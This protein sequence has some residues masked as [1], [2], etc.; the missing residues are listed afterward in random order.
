MPKSYKKLQKLLTFDNLMIRLDQQFKEMFDHR[1]NNATYSLA[2]VLKSG[3][4]MFSLKSP[5]LLSFQEQTRIE[6]RNLKQIY[7]IGKIPAD[8]QMRVILDGVE[9]D[10]IRDMFPV[11]YGRLKQAGVIKEYEY[12]KKHLLVSIDGVEHF[13]STRI[14]CANCTR[15]T[16]RDGV[17]SYQ[18]AALAAVIV[19]PEQKEVLAL[20]FEPIV[21]QDGED[22]N[23]CERVAVKRLSESLNERYPDTLMI[24]VEDALYANAPHIRQ[25]GEQGWNFIISVKPESHKSL[26]KQFAWRRESGQVKS[27]ETT[28]E[29]RLRRC[30]SWTEDLYLCDRAADLKVNCLWY[31]EQDAA[32]KITRWTWITRLPLERRTVEKV[33]NAGRA[34]W[35]IENETFNT[36]KNQ[37]YNFEHNDGHGEKNLASVLAMLMML[38]FLVDQIQERCCELFARLRAGLRTRAKLWETMRSLF[39]VVA[40]RSMTSLYI[41]MAGLYEIKLN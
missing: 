28:D 4:A 22:K 5:S 32:G 37:G 39:K 9:P 29:K 20:D 35:K 18:H 26:F 41:R 6:R 34:R 3:F 36:L 8:T 31:E 23:D 13:N 1:R 27:F 19:H 30:F 15:K 10:S 21:C 14:H 7:R 12:W 33:M 24:L 25:I 2:D 11:F 40:L 17:V 38:A 16:R